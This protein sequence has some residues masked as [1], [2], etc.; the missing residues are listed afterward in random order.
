MKHHTCFY[1]WRTAWLV[2]LALTLAVPLIAPAAAQETQKI[3][4]PG[5]YQGY[6][7]P[8]YDGWTRTSQYITVRDGTRLAVDIFR[9][10]QHGVVVDD[11]LPVIWTQHRY[12][13]ANVDSEGQVV[14]LVDQV[15]GL[16][17]MIR[18]GYVIGVADVRGGGAS[19]G[20]RH[21]E[22][23]PEETW[24]SYDLTEWFAVQPWC[25]GNVGMFGLS[26]LAITQY[27]AAST[28]PPHLKAIF[29]MMALFDLYSFA[30]PGG[31]F[32]SNFALKW[33]AGNL[34]LDRV[35][36]A[37]PV[38]ADTDGKL[39]DEAMAEHSGNWDVYS[40]AKDSPYRD[41]LGPENTP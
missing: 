18:Y 38:D 2:A 16:Q 1:S 27:M 39:L 31:I 19:F 11:P 24:D 21:G 13:R 29:P 15:P 22:F 10:T 34:L 8:L 23:S 4:R 35:M 37:A 40:I 33:G 6:S 36:R 41:S 30:Y 14:S 25:S 20:T 32:Q 12:H 17:T 5:L 7:E 9:P 26:Y 28:R 3:S